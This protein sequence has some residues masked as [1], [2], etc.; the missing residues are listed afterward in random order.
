MPLHP[1]HEPV[2]AWYTRAGR[3]LPWREPDRSSWGVLV[4]EVMLQ[5]TPVL[6][7]LPVWQRWLSR[8]PTPAALATEPVGEAIRSWGNLGYPRRALRLHE[9]ATAM[10]VRHG[11]DVPD[12]HTRLLALP[13][14]GTYTAA[15]V[16]SFAFGQR[17]AVVD[18]NVR[19]VLARAA[20]GV[21]YPPPHPTTAEMRL[22]WELV[23]DERAT[24]ARWAAA[25]MELGA[26]TCTARTPHCED[27]PALRLCRWKAA[28]RP[29]HD[30]PGRRSQAYTGTDRHVRGQILAVLRS[31][32]R[33]VTRAALVAAVPDSALRDPRQRDR[34][35]D[36]LV[37]DGLV[38]PLPRARFRLPA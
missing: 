32:R 23:P 19:R 17:Q 11:G 18:T 36:T 5:Q 26:L 4:S 7:V 13:G 10:V 8:W 14:I 27:C 29:P 30:R 12:D 35:L 25:V 3:D 37:A 22:A 9:A 33:P 20:E 2:L 15:A 28:G 1:L 24:A 21:Q 6:R 16:A 38:E 31:T 34:C